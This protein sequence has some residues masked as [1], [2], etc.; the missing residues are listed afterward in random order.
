MEIYNAI[1]DFLAKTWEA[2][3]TKTIEIWN[4]LKK[5]LSETWEN[6]KKLITDT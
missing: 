1:K 5:W 6:I 3:K 2:I 4:S